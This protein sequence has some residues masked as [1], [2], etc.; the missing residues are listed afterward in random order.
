MEL[1]SPDDVLA[2]IASALPPTCRDN[3]IIVGSLAAG[4]HF[5][6]G[7]PERAIRTKDV[8]WLAWEDPFLTGRDAC[9]LKR[10]REESLQE[11]R[12]RLAYVIPML[13]ILDAAA[14]GTHHSP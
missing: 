11:T 13:Q 4:F 9:Q 7:D 2:Q 5:F 1:M 10:E 6:S 12:K 3:V 14:N 8:D